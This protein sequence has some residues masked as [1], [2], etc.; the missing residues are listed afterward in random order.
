MTRGGPSGRSD[1][2]ARRRLLFLAPSPP[3]L[4]AAHGGSRMVAQLISLLALRHDV[5]LLCLRFPDELP[6]DDVLKERCAVIEEVG[7]PLLAHSPWR[8]WRES[9]RL[10]LLIAGAPPWVIGCSVADFWTR[11]GNFARDWQPEVVQIEYAVMGQYAQ[12]FD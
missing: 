11:L 1:F 12:A 5:A 8:L 6:V 2:A 10:R 3:R 4:D 7:R 9:R